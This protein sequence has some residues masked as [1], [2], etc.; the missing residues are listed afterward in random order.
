MI[1]IPEYKYLDKV[2]K[3]NIP[4]E[5]F[6]YIK[7]YLE[8]SIN[9]YI[10]CCDIISGK[11]IRFKIK[12]AKMNMSLINGF[13][14]IIT[15]KTY[16]QIRKNP[17][18]E[19]VLTSYAKNEFKAKY[20]EIKKLLE[21]L[22]D[23]KSELYI[24]KIIKSKPEILFKICEEFSKIYKSKNNIV[25]DNMLNKIFDYDRF[26]KSGFEIDKNLKAPFKKWSAY[27]Y[28]EKL[29]VNVCP[30]CNRIYTYTVRKGNNITRPELDHYFPKSEY[31][32]LA[33]SFFNLIPSCN[34]CNSTIK[35]KRN[36]N[37]NTNLH[38]Y[39]DEVDKSYKFDYGMDDISIFDG[40]KDNMQ[41]KIYKDGV[42]DKSNNTLKFFKIEEIYQKHKDTVVN[43]ILLRKRYTNG[44][45]KEISDLL[46]DNY[47]DEILLSEDELF[48]DLFHVN[49]EE[50][51]DTSLGKL[52]KDTI[53]KLKLW[54]K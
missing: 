31:P 34:I 20:N 51:I 26:I 2:K 19:K 14:T 16:D 5:H 8:D 22:I 15:N 38:P 43:L 4:Q 24:E 12:F 3:L 45:L 50:V 13:L 28:C 47:D 48:N 11:S 21:V 29:S 39:L 23:D 41:L 27:E 36:L 9:F 6:E 25:L 33:L 46:N 53:E 54:G 44:I 42:D 35:G 37:L 17:D 49:L 10:T 40:R 18:K 1:K 30:Y 52:K 32:I 7:K